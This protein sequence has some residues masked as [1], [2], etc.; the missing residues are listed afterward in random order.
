MVAFSFS[1]GGKL[2]FLYYV[3]NPHDFS[4]D[5]KVDDPLA[6]TRNWSTEP[7]RLAVSNSLRDRRWRHGRVADGKVNVLRDVLRGQ[8]DQSIDDG[9]QVIRF[10]V[11]A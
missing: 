7:A 8:L 11:N 10:F 1:F 3:H 9:F 2:V 4:R 6:S 5:M